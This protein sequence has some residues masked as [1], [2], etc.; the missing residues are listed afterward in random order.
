MKIL[1][2]SDCRRS[3]AAVVLAALLLFLITN[4][5]GL[6]RTAQSDDGFSSIYSALDTTNRSKVAFIYS[7][8][9]RPQ[10]RNFAYVLRGSEKLLSIASFGERFFINYLVQNGYTH[11]LVPESSANSGEIFHKWGDKGSISISLTAPMFTRVASTAGGSDVV[12]FEIN[13][14]QVDDVDDQIIPYHIDWL[15]SVRPAFYMPITT[16]VERG[17]HRY[18]YSVSYENGPDV[19]WVFHFAGFRP[20]IP[21][22]K[23]R[24]VDTNSRFNVAM[25]LAAAYGPNARPQVIRVDV[26]GKNVHV[27]ELLAG[28]GTEVTVEVKTDEVITIHSV[29]PCNQPRVFEPNDLDER[30]FCFG[31]SDL[32][33]TPIQ[34]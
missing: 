20:E 22:F 25:S 26:S 5:I 21:A 15:D 14:V 13:R 3:F 27:V 19:S 30:R 32:R 10:N 4:P 6:D 33:V 23:I 24:S 1:K 17:F 18:D 34:N 8:N 2:L 31:L 9:D 11:I 28:S 12:L 16:Y 7:W 29:L